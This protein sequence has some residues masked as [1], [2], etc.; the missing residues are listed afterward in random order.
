MA[1]KKTYT[2]TVSEAREELLDGNAGVA[3]LRVIEVKDDKDQVVRTTKAADSDDDV[4]AKLAAA[5][6]PV[7][8]WD[9]GTADAVVERK[10]TDMEKGCL[11]CLVLPV[12]LFVLVFVAFLIP[13]D[14]APAEHDAVEAEI[15]CEGLVKEKLR[16]PSTA[17]FSQQDTAGS[18]T[19]WSSNG[20]VDAENAFGGTVSG[21]YTC[22]ITFTG[23][24]EYRGTANIT[25]R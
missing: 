4:R 5:G 1:K 8:T 6:Y 15:L 21:R 20:V 11:G 22:S 14:D 19:G 23:E 25:E 10:R 2:A 12:A 9:G 7:K 3:R 17:K 13:K 16:A 18:G 24:D